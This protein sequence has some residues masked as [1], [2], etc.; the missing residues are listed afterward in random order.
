MKRLLLFVAI[1][2]ACPTPAVTQ[3]QGAWVYDTAKDEMTDEL[4]FFLSRDSR[5]TYSTRGDL[6]TGTLVWRCSAA[7][8][9]E[10]FILLDKYFAG[11][12][13]DQVLVETRFDSSS[14][15]ESVGWN[16]STT[17]RGVFMPEEV[18][19]TFTDRVR[20]SNRLLVRVTDPP[21]GEAITY[22]FNLVGF[23]SAY[24]RLE[25]NCPKDAPRHDEEGV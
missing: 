16:L 11:D 1:L 23:T 7:E 22:S 25:P 13:D 19:P 8:G 5:P 2:I 9:R 4:R 17:R 6:V 3:T 24:R 10:I 20:G 12:A 18:I 14:P 15:S 21:D